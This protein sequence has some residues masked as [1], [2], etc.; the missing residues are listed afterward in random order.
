M[1]RNLLNDE[2]AWEFHIEL[3]GANNTTTPII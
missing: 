1:V 2:A 3:Q